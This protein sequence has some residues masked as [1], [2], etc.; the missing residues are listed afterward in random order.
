[1]KRTGGCTEIDN[2][3]GHPVAHQGVHA[4]KWGGGEM[5]GCG[6]HEPILAAAM[7]N[8]DHGPDAEVWEACRK[9]ARDCVK[10]GPGETR[11]ATWRATPVPAQIADP[12]ATIVQEAWDTHKTRKGTLTETVEKW[13]TMVGSPRQRGEVAREKGAPTRR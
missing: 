10:P 7:V 3:L 2:P 9:G 1:M 4:D 13:P 12:T 8:S 5:W 6:G 11:E